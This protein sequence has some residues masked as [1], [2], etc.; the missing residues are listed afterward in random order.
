MSHELSRDLPGNAAMPND[1][2]RP[3]YG[4]WDAA[5][6]KQVLDLSPRSQVSRQVCTLPAKTAEIDQSLKACVGGCLAE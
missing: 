3:Q 2:R 4:D 6:A 1:D 5:L